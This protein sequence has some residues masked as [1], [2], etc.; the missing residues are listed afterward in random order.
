M[1]SLGLV[2]LAK[3]SDFFNIGIDCSDK[4]YFHLADR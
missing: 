3:L 4:L 2:T 1:L